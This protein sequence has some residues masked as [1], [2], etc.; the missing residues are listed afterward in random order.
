ML[1]IKKIISYCEL[2]RRKPLAAKRLVNGVIKSKFLKR[3]P[4]RNVEIQITPDC[5]SKCEMCFSSKLKCG[6]K[7]LIQP[8]EV[9]LF[10]EKCLRLDAF[11]AVITGG[12]PFMRPDLFEIIAALQPR[13]T[14]IGLLTN[15][16]SV[17]EN[18][19]HRLKESMI[20]YL[21]VSLDGLTAEEN[22]EL[23]GVQGHFDKAMN[24]IGYA[25]KYSLLTAI[26]FT[27]T[28]KNI[29]RLADICEFASINGLL[30]NPAPAVPVGNW[31]NNEDVLLSDEDWRQL[32]A[33]IKKYPRMRL[34]FSLNYEGRS[35][36]PAG[37]EKFCLSPYGDVM[38]CSLNH[39]SF[40]NIRQE[41]I[42][43]IWREMTRFSYFQTSY[44]YCRPA[45]EAAYINGVTKKINQANES[46]VYYR[47]L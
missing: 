5:N 22:D 21:Q 31:E 1:P 15:C 8:E 3:K 39:V 46:P 43:D 37:R 12:E 30:L 33:L 32:D 10:W 19:V 6:G 24:V 35:Q 40:G 4:L 25:K 20:D 23:R 26:S 29:N 44:K 27:I 47:N 17:N 41:E 16:L 14:I 18:D 7:T 13:K 9:K 28:H 36:C 11:C 38:G 45:G 2:L 42:K 34:C